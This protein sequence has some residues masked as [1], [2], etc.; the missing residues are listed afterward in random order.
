M[1]AVYYQGV[2]AC[3]DKHHGAVEVE[4]SH[5][6]GNAELVVRIPVGE[7]VLPLLQDVA[8][9]DDADKTPIL[10]NDREALDLVCIHRLERILCGDALRSRDQFLGHVPGDLRIAFLWKDC[11]DI[12]AADD[13]DH[14]I[15]LDDGDTAD[16]ILLH[17]LFDFGDRGLWPYSHDLALDQIL[18]LFDDLDFGNLPLSGHVPVNDADAAFASHRYRHQRLGYRIHGGAHEWNI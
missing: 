13:A 12:P 16:T 17:D 11:P 15:V 4:W 7:G 3:L 14:F 8:H 5:G 6:S 2:Y 10:I 9:R 1:S 18:G